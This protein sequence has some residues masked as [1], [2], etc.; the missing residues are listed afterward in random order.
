[1]EQHVESTLQEAGIDGEH[2]D[3]PLLRQSRR[4]GHGVALGDAHVEKPLG[5]RG[6]ELLQARALR[7]GGGDG[8]QP[9]VL[10]RHLHKLVTQDVGKIDAPPQVRPDSGVKG[11]HAVAPLRLDLGGLVALSFHRAHVEQHRAGHL[12]GPGQGGAQLLHIVPVHRPQVGEAH[13]LEHGAGVDGPLHAA[14]DAVVQPVEPPSAGEVLQ[15]CPVAL[16][17][18][19]VPRAQPQAAEVGGHAPHV[20]VDGHAVV[21]EDHHHRLPGG[22]GVVE[23]LVGQAAGEGPVPDE[24][25]H[26]VV[27]PP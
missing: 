8:A 23:P 11:G 3:H 24:G 21:V 7:H 12:P 15:H 10:P 27:L 14:L 17:E 16:L 20:G 18:P 22:P 9:A 19:V 1:M 5:P 6:G 25:R 26:A 4:H 13:V 2:R